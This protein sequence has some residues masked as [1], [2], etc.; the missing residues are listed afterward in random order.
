MRGVP[1]PW[2]TCASSWAPGSCHGAVCQGSRHRFRDTR[3]RG[4]PPSMRELGQAAGLPSTSSV[5]RQIGA[6][7]KTRPP[8]RAD[9]V[10]PNTVPTAAG[11]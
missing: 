4:S 10:R 11:A 5:A 3:D 6:R 7:V 2:A 1:P 9:I 8:R